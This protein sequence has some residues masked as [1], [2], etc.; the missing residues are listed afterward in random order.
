MAYDPQTHHR[1]SIRLRGYDYSQAGAYFVTVCAHQKEHLFGQ[2]VEGEMRTNEYGEIVRLYWKHLPR[3]H[4]GVQLDSFI[5]MPNHIHGIIIV[6]AVHEP[7]K[8]AGV[9]HELP[10]RHATGAIRKSPLR[11]R[12]LLPNVIG[13]FK[14]KTGKRINQLRARPGAAVWQRNYYEHIIRSE[15]ELGKIREYIATNPLRWL[16]DPENPGREVDV[17]DRW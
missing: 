4:P 8:T 1:R 12:M 17:P 14:M 9:I 15:D 6:G 2:I 11:R 5:V 7:P 10:L 16:S 13:Y 3:R